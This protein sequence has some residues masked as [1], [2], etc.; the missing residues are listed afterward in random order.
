MAVVVSV[1]F[2]ATTSA[3][4]TVQVSA[5]PVAGV[6]GGQGASGTA[7]SATVMPAGEG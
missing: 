5:A 3:P 4:V 6:P 1:T 7:G 2:P